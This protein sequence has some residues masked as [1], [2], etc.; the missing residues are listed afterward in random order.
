MKDEGQDDEEGQERLEES[1]EEAEDQEKDEEL[2]PLDHCLGDP[3]DETQERLCIK[4]FCK[5]VDWNAVADPHA[6]DVRPVGK[7]VRNVIVSDKNIT[8]SGEFRAVHPGLTS[9][10][11]PNGLL[12]R[13]REVCGWQRS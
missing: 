9:P 7:L 10:L 6:N 1:D 11:D 2:E 4:D 3:N 5:S 13:L 12:R 8:R